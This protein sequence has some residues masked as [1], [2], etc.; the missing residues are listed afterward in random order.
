MQLNNFNQLPI[1]NILEIYQF[2]A[3]VNLTD[4]KEIYKSN[5]INKYT[6]NNNVLKEYLI[7]ED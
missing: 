3:D 7:L 6:F 4:W 5:E 2:G 1:S